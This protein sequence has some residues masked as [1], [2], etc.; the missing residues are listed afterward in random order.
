VT[1]EDKCSDATHL[2]YPESNEN[3]GDKGFMAFG[4]EEG[5]AFLMSDTECR[6]PEHD[7]RESACQVQT[8]QKAKALCA[9]P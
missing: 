6:T 2:P 7:A 1:T 5:C 9:L 4:N 8:P 3:Q